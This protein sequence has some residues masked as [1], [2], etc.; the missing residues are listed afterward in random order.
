MSISLKTESLP[1]GAIVIESRFTPHKNQQIIRNSTA[2]FKIV[3]A[4]RRF[5]KTVFALNEL[6]N[7]ALSHSG[8]RGWYVAPTYRQAKDIAWKLLFSYLPQEF[9]AKKNESELSIDLINGSEISLKGADNPDSLRGVG[10]HFVVLDEYAE[11]KPETWTEIIRPMLVDTKGK[12]LFIGTPKGYNHFW[13]LYNKE[14]DDSDYKSFHFA[15]VDNLALEGI[16]E[17]VEKARTETDPIRFS[18]EYEANF[19]SLVGRPRFDPITLKAMFYKA[20]KPIKGNLKFDGETV[21]FEEN[22][23]GLVEVYNFPDDKTFGAIGADVAEGREGDSSSASFINF[24]TLTEDATINTN[25]LDPS[26]FAFEVWKLGHWYNEALVAVENNGPGLACILPLKNESHTIDYRPAYRRL[27]YKDEFDEATK[28]KTKKVGWS[29]TAKSK[30]LMIDKLA[31]L[32]R[33]GEIDIPSADTIR[34]L[35]TY[36]VEEDGKM[37]AAPGC[38]DDRVMALAIAVMMYIMRPNIET[39]KKIRVEDTFVSHYPVRR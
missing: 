27:Y 29:T 8:V 10:L 14:K 39:T 11:M 30:P 19:E 12:A 33:N 18:Q 1:E 3:V 6:I 22:P 13:E 9:I 16:T 23:T 37:N 35:Q 15:T 31:E 32:I 34:E 21:F 28:K 25:K 26:Q 4:G 5:G 7:E 38:H 2:R 24:E 17:E 20:R 36:V